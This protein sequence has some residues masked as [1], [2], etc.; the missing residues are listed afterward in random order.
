MIPFFIAVLF[1]C[2]DGKCSFYYDQRQFL[3]YEQC[4]KSLAI[5]LYVMKEEKPNR[6]VKGACLAFKKNEA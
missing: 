3:S 1:A 4:E 6:K 2:Q 5:Q